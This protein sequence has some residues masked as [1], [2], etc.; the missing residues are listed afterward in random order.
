VQILARQPK[1][2]NIARETL[3]IK[4]TF[5][6]LQ[7]KK[8]KIVQKII[9]GQNKSKLKISMTTKGSSHKQVIVPMKGNSANNFIKNLSIYIININWM[10]K[11]I[12]FCV[13]AD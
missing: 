9:S 8:I 6:N 2:T 13:M 1:S 12:K 11:N 7:N 10:L 4:K 3:K 5:S